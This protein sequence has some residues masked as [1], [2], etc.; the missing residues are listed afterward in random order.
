MLERRIA[1]P[2]IFLTGHGDVSTSVDAMKRGAVDFLE[3]PVTREVL[4]GT[5]QQALARDAE[6]REGQRERD[7]MKAR[8][9]LLTPREHEVMEYVIAGRLNKQIAADLGISLKTVKAHRAKV[10]QKMVARSVPDL[11]AMCRSRGSKPGRRRF[12]RHARGRELLGSPHQL[13]DGCHVH[14]FHDARAVR[15]HRSLGG[16]QRVADLL[17]EATGHDARHDL[18][19]AR[20]ERRVA[21]LSSISCSSSSLRS[22]SC[23]SARAMASSRTAVGTGLVRKSSAPFRIARTVLG[24]SPWALRKMTGCAWPRRASSSCRSSPLVPGMRKSTM[25]HAGPFGVV[26]REVFGGRSIEAGAWPAADKAR[27]MAVRKRASSSTTCTTP[28]RS[29]LTFM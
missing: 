9:Q 1:M 28:G 23:S 18:A 17:V 12:Q 24:M 6:R 19:L 13:R 5:I 11:V 10:M 21:A 15:L 8:A 27:P 29:M 7:A 14:L 16:L 20:R 25:R 22:T 2:V 4:L 26:H 3:K